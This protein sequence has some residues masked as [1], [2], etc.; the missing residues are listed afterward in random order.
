M[1]Q[2]HRAFE[3]T[4]HALSQICGIKAGDTLSL[5]TTWECSESNRLQPG[6]IPLNIN[7][8]DNWSTQGESTLTA[9]LT[10]YKKSLT[11]QV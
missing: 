1:Q 3:A 4:Q 10:I 2:K 7:T 8:S 5:K 11:N 6:T 9:V